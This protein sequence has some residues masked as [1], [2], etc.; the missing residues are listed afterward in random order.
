[1]PPI[2][3]SGVLSRIRANR[4]GFVL[5]VQG[6]ETQAS[7]AALTQVR[8]ELRSLDLGGEAEYGPGLG[9][10]VGPAYVS[11]VIPCPSGPFLYIDATEVPDSALRQ[12]PNLV[13]KRLDDEALTHAVVTSPPSG[14]PLDS[15]AEVPRGVAL[16]LLPP[17]IYT[18]KG[19]AVMPETWLDEADAWV[20][21]NDYGTVPLWLSIRSVHVEIDAKALRRT[22]GIFRTSGERCLAVTGDLSSLFRGANLG[23]KVHPYVVLGFGGPAAS[24]ELLLEGV[25]QLKNIARR[26]APALGYSFIAI[27]PTSFALANGRPLP[28]RSSGL[29]GARLVWRMCDLIALDAF[30]WQ[31]L[32]P[33][34]LARLGKLPL[35]S[36][37]LGGDRLEVSIG[38]PRDWLPGKPEN[39][40]VRSTGRKELGGCLLSPD[41]ASSLLRTV[42]NQ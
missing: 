41:K 8:D 28:E 18:P 31:V 21:R 25:E 29:A 37:Q 17:P 7:I 12:I 6:A 30:C 23:H 19:H 26:L 33:K 42:T 11:D 24:D 32:T 27:E 34:H 13:V 35:G 38:E 1:M 10:T 22:L 36:Q 3:A 16:H 2:I 9:D 4:D 40:E 39:V 20:H 5:Q 15:L 14:G